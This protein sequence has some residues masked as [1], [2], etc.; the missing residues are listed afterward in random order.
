MRKSTLSLLFAI[1]A[2]VVVPPDAHAQ[3]QRVA[4]V[5]G[6]SDYKNVSSLKNPVNDAADM[7]AALSR[8][9]F[10]VTG[11]SNATAQDTRKAL[12]DFGEK[13]RQADIAVVFYSGHGIQADGVNWLIPVDGRANTLADVANS[14]TS[15]PQIL[16]QFDGVGKIGIVFLDAAR[17]NPFT[18]PGQ[19]APAGPAA[20]A[21]EPKNVMVGFATSAGRKVADGE[22]RN[23]PYTA[24]LLKYIE[25][26][27]LELTRLMK[28]LRDD[29]MK[30][31]ANEQLPAFY[32][33]ATDDDIFL[34]PPR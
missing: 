2:T 25:Q 31:T 14:S 20:P 12:S 9:G 17:D 18:G 33:A 3:D 11:L 34:V 15:L 5:I 29:V 8:M 24:A 7:G 6:N 28:Q 30:A 22:G 4:L 27:G 1:L 10:A 16:E 21:E 32:M 26:P 13:V 19:S 23:S